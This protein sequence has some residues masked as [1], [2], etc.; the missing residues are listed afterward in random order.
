MSAQRALPRLTSWPIITT[1]KNYTHLWSAFAF[2][3]GLKEEEEGTYD[4]CGLF[5]FLFFFNSQ[6]G[7][8]S[9]K[10]SRYSVCS[11]DFLLMW[12]RGAVILWHFKLLWLLKAHVNALLYRV[13]FSKAMLCFQ[14]VFWRCDS[15]GEP[16]G[17]DL[18]CLCVEH[19]SVVLWFV[20]LF[21]W[22]MK[23]FRG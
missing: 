1:A 13:V 10:R 17:D 5:V 4:P 3:F 6:C 15:S 9:F 16:K 2:Q 14:P 19:H 23:P 22:Q 7:A 21:I 8:V 11:Q 12:K 20:G 18:C